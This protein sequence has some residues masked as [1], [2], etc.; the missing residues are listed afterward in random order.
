MTIARLN[1]MPTLNTLQ[2]LE[3][4]SARVSLEAAERRLEDLLE[5]VEQMQ[6]D[7][8]YKASIVAKLARCHGGLYPEAE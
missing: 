3:L 6:N 5:E 8:G 4:R 2:E 1:M 7:G